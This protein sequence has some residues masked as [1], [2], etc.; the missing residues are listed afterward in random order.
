M[1]DDELELELELS[2]PC[3][4]MVQHQDTNGG[5]EWEYSLLFPLC[6]TIVVVA[7][8]NEA[9]SSRGRVATGIGSQ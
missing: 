1:P 8:T 6:S 7:A 9:R 4:P 3:N 5:G 2:W